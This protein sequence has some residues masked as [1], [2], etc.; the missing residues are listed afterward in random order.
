MRRRSSML[1]GAV[2]T[3]AQFDEISIYW[4]QEVM[5]LQAS[6]EEGKSEE[7]PEDEIQVTVNRVTPSMSLQQPYQVELTL[8]REV[9]V[10]DAGENLYWIPHGRFLFLAVRDDGYEN[11]YHV[12]PWHLYPLSNNFLEYQLY[13]QRLERDPRLVNRQRRP[14]APHTNGGTAIPTRLN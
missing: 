2:M 14:P 8:P 10:A 5:L 4:R 1:H 12:M 11:L 6:Q 3:A 7:N 9:L 13:H